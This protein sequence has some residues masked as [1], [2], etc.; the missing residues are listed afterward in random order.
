M[1]IINGIKNSLATF[2]IANLMASGGIAGDSASVNIEGPISGGARGFAYS[3]SIVDLKPFGYTESEYFISGKA[4]TFKPAPGTTLASDGRWQVVPADEMPYKTRILVRRPA[5]EKFN[6]TVIVEFMQEYFG[7]ERDTNFR[8]NAEALLREGFG[9]VGVS[10]HHEG[11]DDPKPMQTMKYGDLTFTMGMTMA[12]WDPQ[13]Y[14]S[15]SVPTSDLSYDILSQ[16][17]HLVGPNRSKTDSDPLRGLNVRKVIAVGN[18]IGGHRLAIYINAVQPITHAFDGFYLQDLTPN[19][20]QLAKDVETPTSQP[21]RTDVD[22]PVMVFNTTTAAMAGQQQEGPNIRFWEPAGSS[23]TTGPA[24]V[25]I[26]AANKRDFDQGG[27]FC[28]PQYANTFP[29]HYMSSAAIVALDHWLKSGKPAPSFP[30]LQVIGSGDSAVTPFDQHGNS[31][32]GLRTPWVDVPIA[33]YDWRGEC[34]AG[35]GR[36]YPFTPDQLKSLYKSPADYQAKFRKATDEAVRRGVLLPEDAKAAVA[37][38]QQV[39]W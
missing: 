7:S 30:Q 20:L 16:A 17:A 32:G 31:A 38:A 8:W 10:L 21:L 26:A 25:R 22:V 3:S 6:G 5:A 9:W 1:R 24:T 23:H 37:E 36:T 34:P 13:R 35:A 28:P 29:V 18:T 2:L 11:I 12:R 27:G 39:T 19:K 15:L 14:G 4:H 33:R